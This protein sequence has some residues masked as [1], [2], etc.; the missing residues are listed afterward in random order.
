[1][2]KVHN[3]V[4]AGLCLLPTTLWCPL[5][6]IQEC[7]K[8]L[9]QETIKGPLA[10]G[11][12]LSA[13]TL[14]RA[15]VC[16]RSSQMGRL[17]KRPLVHKLQQ[18]GKGTSADHRCCSWHSNKRSQDGHVLCHKAH[19]ACCVSTTAAAPR[20]RHAQCLQAPSTCIYATEQCSV[21]DPSSLSIPHNHTK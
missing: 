4:L 8:Q 15:S 20:D 19:T 7:P 16:G 1:M 9:A 18:A 10:L 17:F 6:L 14:L 12:S 11:K 3:G 21:A 5:S 13:Y 2:S